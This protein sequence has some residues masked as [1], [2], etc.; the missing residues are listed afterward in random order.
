[1]QFAEDP[2]IN[3]IYQGIKRDI[4]VTYDNECYRACLILIYCGIDAMAYLDMPVNQA[5]VHSSDFI[6]WVERYLSPNLKNGGTQVTG[7]EL[8]IA[9]C[10]VVHS[11]GVESPKTKSGSAR[12]IGYMVGGGESIV[13]DATVTLNLILL[14]LE[15]L[16]DAFFAAID[17]FLI[18]GYADK[19][20]Q[21]IL[22]G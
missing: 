6:Q 21:P 1:M 18:E 4:Q 2:L 20:K 10:A 5:E 16:R 22:E 3:A 13:S 19:Q 15:T 9:R 11:Y 8:Y 12:A 7:K 14:R 17:R